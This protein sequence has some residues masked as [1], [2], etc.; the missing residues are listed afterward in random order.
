MNKPPKNRRAKTERQYRRNRRIRIRSIRRNPPDY[1]KLAS[2]IIELAE[3][4]AE[5]DAQ[6]ELARKQSARQ[7]K[8]ELAERQREQAEEGPATKRP[9]DNRPPGRPSKRRDAGVLYDRLENDDTGGQAG[10]CC[11]RSS[12]DSG[13][14]CAGRMRWRLNSSWPPC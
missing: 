13:S 4:Q 10:A 12:S 7:R 6:A 1:K 14:S 5:A 9:K 2:A 8:E 11:L 3:A